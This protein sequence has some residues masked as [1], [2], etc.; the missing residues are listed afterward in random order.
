[1]KLLMTNVNTK[2]EIVLQNKVAT[3]MI[4]MLKSKG[5]QLKNSDYS[6][7]KLDL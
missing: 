7:N 2:S 4:E 3:F 5:I 1:M 6:F